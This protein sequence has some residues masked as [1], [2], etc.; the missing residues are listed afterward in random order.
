MVLFSGRDL[1]HDRSKIFL[2]YFKGLLEVS[3]AL[4]HLV[5]IGCKAKE[6]LTEGFLDRFIEDN[7]GNLLKAFGIEKVKDLSLCQVEGRKPSSLKLQTAE[8]SENQ[9]QAE[10]LSVFQYFEAV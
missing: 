6:N 5:V 1:A 3:S 7:L 4:L 9:F 2:V 10:K 8:E